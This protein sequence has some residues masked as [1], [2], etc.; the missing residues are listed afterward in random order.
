MHGDIFTEQ[1]NSKRFKHFVWP[2]VLMMLVLAL[3]Y[4]ID[5]IFVA[6]LVGEG[7]LAAINIAYPIQG[8]M[9]GF[10]VMLAAGSSALVG[11]EMGKG[12][13]RKADDMFTFVCV[14]GTLL[15]IAF[16]L[17]CLV[18]MTP[19]V[20]ILGATE[21]LTEDCH[22]FL[23]VFVWGCPVAFLGVLFEFFIRVDGKP[24]FTIVL[25][26]AGGVVHLGLDILLMGPLHMGLR[27]AAIANV[28]GLFATAV[29]G[30]IYFLMMETRLNFSKFTLAWKYIAHSF[31][32][33]SPEFINESAAG[34]MV[35]CYN[36]V[37]VHITGETGVAAVAVVL[38]I[39]YFFMSAHMGY[40]VGV[41]PLLSYYY[42]AGDHKNLN[43][44]MR[45]SRIFILTA[46]VLIAAVCA[47]GA[48]LLAR[49]YASPDTELYEMSVM[50][51]RIVSVSLLAIG[52]NVFA[53]GFFTSFGNGLVSAAISISRGLVLLVIGL[54]VLSHFFG[55][56]GAWMALP[57]AD[58]LT[59]G[60]SFGLM[61]KNRSRYNYRIFG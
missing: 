13:D 18:C 30:L 2:S 32:N 40:Q 8:L 7:G 53:S 12:N 56:N 60:L 15:G 39:H 21:D 25:Y 36:L 14:F 41:M 46:S 19:I 49:V 23:N 29:L 24:A 57:F 26:I 34:I 59:L 1:L 28:G 58:V 54:F 17:F 38:N 55:M 16:T 48:P 45:Y 35:F 42:G 9:W 61:A 44:V 33:G 50:G 43:M 3:Y 37:V 52:V 47:L 27:G 4:T 20:N 11:I 51:L 10:A 6:N 5:S 22:I 31:I